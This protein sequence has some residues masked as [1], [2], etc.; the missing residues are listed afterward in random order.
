MVEAIADRVRRYILDGTDRDLRR[1]LS[2]S[3]DAAEMARS[4]FRRVGVEEGWNAIDCGCGPLGGLAVIA[5]MVGPSGRVV[6]VD[7]S[8]PAVQQART[9]AASLGLSN[10][11]VFGG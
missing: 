7:F 2:I 9:V 5:E 11:E 8:E 1:L 4:A 6:G 3:Q 10:V